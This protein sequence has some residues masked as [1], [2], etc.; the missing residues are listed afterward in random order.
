[1]GQALRDL[2]EPRA[3][4]ERAKALIVEAIAE[5]DGCGAPADIAAHLDLAVNRIEFSLINS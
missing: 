4:L 5:L 2:N 3:G 1:M